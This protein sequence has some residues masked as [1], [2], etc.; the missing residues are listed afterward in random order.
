MA[1]QQRKRKST[2]LKTSMSVFFFLLS[3][4]TYNQRAFHDFIFSQQHNRI[5]HIKP[6]G[7]ITI[8][9]LHRVSEHTDHKKPTPAY[10]VA[11]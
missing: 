1:M 3:H 11:F 7:E 6:W 4:T 9:K 10:H 8:E 5:L 2:A